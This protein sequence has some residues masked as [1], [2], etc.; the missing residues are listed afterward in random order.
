MKKKDD[1][2]DCVE[3]MHEAQRAIQAETAGMTHE[4]LAAWYHEQSLAITARWE[5]EKEHRPD[6][7]PV[8]TGA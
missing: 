4:E 6:P 1:E 3:M 7:K 2:F 5:A 8:V